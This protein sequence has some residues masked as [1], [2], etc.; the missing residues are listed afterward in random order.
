MKVVIFI[1]ILFL[2][3][4]ASAET[5]TVYGPEVDGFKIYDVDRR[6]RNL[7]IYDYR[8]HEY[9]YMDIDRGGD[10][11]DWQ[12]NKFYDVDMDRNGRGGSVYDYEEGQY[13]YFDID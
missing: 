6:G 13:Y 5:V 10:V 7:T 2:A 9:R 1:L 11:Y 3:S 4:I 12:E 8:E